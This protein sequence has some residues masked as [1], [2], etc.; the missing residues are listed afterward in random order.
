[1]SFFPM[2]SQDQLISFIVANNAMEKLACPPDEVLKTYQRKTLNP[3]AAGH[4]SSILYAIKL[5]GTKTFPARMTYEFSDPAQSDKNL[6]WL[7]DLHSKLM[8]PIAEY[9]SAVP[10]LDVC[11][12]APADCGNYR[13][14][15][16][17]ILD[18]R[19]G[20]YRIFPKP[21]QVKP[22]MHWWYKDLGTFHL[23]MAPKIDRAVLEIDDIKA[24]NEEAYNKHIQLMCIHPWIDGSGRVGRI[25]ENALRLRWGLSWKTIGEANKLSYVRDIIKYEESEEWSKVIK[26]IDS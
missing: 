21:S 1:M 10:E 25:V 24:V 7:R 26:Q 23:K 13:L 3:L 6:Y 12:I 11:P 16:R 4:I 19:T 9:G 2:P 17:Q 20:G 5:A 18:F 14:Q 15:Y 8:K 22:L